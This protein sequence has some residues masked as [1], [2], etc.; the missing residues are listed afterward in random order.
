[1]DYRMYILVNEDI[2]I[3][4]G[5]LAGQVGHAVA[6][7]I[8]KYMRLDVSHKALEEYMYDL[9]KDYMNGEQKKIILKC[10]QSKLEDLEKQGH[11][12]VRDKG[13]TQL[14]PNTL[15]CINYGIMTP[16]TAPDWIKELKLYN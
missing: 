16:E 4:K 11:V 5:K 6:S 7:Y 15:T 10:P 1:M 8:Y 2:K 13:Y 9:I 14:E 12:R 3:S